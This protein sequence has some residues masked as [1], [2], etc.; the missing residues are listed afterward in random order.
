M[1]Q[2]FV[3]YELGSGKLDYVE[4]E[5]T[6]TPNIAPYSDETCLSILTGNIIYLRGLTQLLHDKS[7]RFID[8]KHTFYYARVEQALEAAIIEC[9]NAKLQVEETGRGI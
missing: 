7:Q 1:A 8:A 3:G 6:T 2:K 5:E 9:E 4:S